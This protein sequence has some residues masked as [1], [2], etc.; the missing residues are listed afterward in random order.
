MFKP[1]LPKLFG[2]VLVAALCAPSW[3]DEVVR[4]GASDLLTGVP[5]EGP[6]TVEQVRAWLAEEPNHRILRPRLP[7]GL[8]AGAPEV[9]GLGANPLTRAKIELGR[10][11]YFDPRLSVDG[12]VSCAS[13]HRPE[14][15]YA[16]P[17]RF[18]VGVRDQAGARN[19]PT[20]ANRLMSGPQFWDGRT[21]SLEEQAIGPIANPIEMGFTHAGVTARLASVEAYLLQFEAIFPD[22]PAVTID[23]VGRAIAAFERALVTGP[24][25]W[26]HHQ[27]LADFE[28]AYEGE[29]DRPDL[30]PEH[31]RLRST[32]AANPLD[33]A[34]LRGAKLFYSA[35]SGCTLCHAGVNFTDERFHN[36]GVGLRGVT[37]PDDPTVDWG[38][39]AIT[40]EESDRGAFK[41]PS[42]RNVSQTA[43][44]LHDGSLD[45][46]EEVIAFYAEGGNAN[47]WLSDLIEPLDLDEQEQADLVAFLEALTGALPEVEQERL[48]E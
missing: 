9:Q 6:L 40:G 33:E 36:L 19:A 15:G 4:L 35:R 16:A 11:L 32:A 43:P 18:G 45:T 17:T 10:Q 7:E 41:T 44:Y 20:A 29:L 24:N 46:L 47:P 30:K 38:R 2:V 1:A 25:P 42:L 37:D 26:D 31:N 21:E 12:T 28:E 3:G 34:A 8:D 13:C 48:P 22:R 5:G 39:H 27:R 23:N 14:H